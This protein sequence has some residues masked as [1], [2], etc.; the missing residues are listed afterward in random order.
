ML[1][2]PLYSRRPDSSFITVATT[3]DASTWMSGCEHVDG[4]GLEVHPFLLIV[5]IDISAQNLVVYLELSRSNVFVSALAI[6]ESVQ[7]FL[8]FG[9]CR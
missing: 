1:S 5:V 8:P 6:I 2:R 9:Q 3:A 4:G 7:I